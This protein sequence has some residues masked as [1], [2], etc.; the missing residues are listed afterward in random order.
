MIQRSTRTLAHTVLLLGSL[1]LALP[2]HAELSVTRG[3]QP[4][5]SLA[6]SAP[7]PEWVYTVRPGESFDEIADI[8]LA[9]NV[10]AIRLLQH[11]GIDNAATIGSGDSLRIPL[12]WLQ[13]QPD[14][15]RVRSVAGQVQLFPAATAASAR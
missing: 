3:S 15:A 10:P 11:N 14:P 5:T 7:V 1:W 8:L 13:R 9:Q 12:A 2:A 6:E 4:G